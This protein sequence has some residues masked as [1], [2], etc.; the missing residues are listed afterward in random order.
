[1][2][3]VRFVLEDGSSYE[4]P[5]DEGGS[6]ADLCDAAPKAVVPFSCR[7]ANCGT[8]R[9]VVLEGQECLHSHDDEE[10]DLLDI[11]RAP[12]THR[13]ACCAKVKAGTGLVVLRAA[14]EDE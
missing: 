10:L 8:C 14:R 3:R 12:P 9:V 11:F 7:S 13:L 2:A 4:T 5:T 6:L 1:M